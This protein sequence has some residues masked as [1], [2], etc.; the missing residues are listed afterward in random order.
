MEAASA[1]DEPDAPPDGRRRAF[2][3]PMSAH[4]TGSPPFVRVSAGASGA[5]GAAA[6]TPLLPTV[7]KRRASTMSG[8]AAEAAAV[9]AAHGT[10]PASGHH[11][12]P[13]QAQTAGG[14][15]VETLYS[16]PSAKIISFSA[17]ARNFV[18]IGS[19]HSRSRNSRRSISSIEDDIEP[20]TLP[21]NSQFE[22]TIAVNA[23]SIYRAPGSVAF[24]SC[25]SAL[26]PILP[27]SQCWCIDEESSKFILQI[28]RP[29]YWRIEIPVG[30]SGENDERARRF[31]EVLEQ[32]LQFEKT[33]CPFKRAFTVELPERPSTPL[34]KRPWTPVRRAESDVS[35]TPPTS[36]S[37]ASLSK[38]RQQPRR[39]SLSPVPRRKSPSVSPPSQFA[40]PV[41][42]SQPLEFTQREW[43]AML[44]EQTK[45]AEEFDEDGRR[46]VPALVA[47]HERI[48]MEVKASE[49]EVNKMGTPWKNNGGTCTP[50]PADRRG[51]GGGGSR[52]RALSL[53][54]DIS[55]MRQG[56]WS[57]AD[58]KWSEVL[59]SDLSTNDSG[60]PFNS[61]RSWLSPGRTLPPSS[62]P[63]SAGSLAAFPTGPEN[64]LPGLA[65][66]FQ[67]TRKV[68]D[69]TGDSTGAT[70]PLEGEEIQK[71]LL[72]LQEQQAGEQQQQEPQPQP[73]QSRIR[74]RA[75]TSSISVT[76]SSISVT[77]SSISVSRLSSLPPAVNILTP[78]RH[79]RGVT[80]SG[81]ASTR[82]EA[83][84]RI[85][86]SIMY[87]V[88]EILLAPPSY[89]I[90]LMLRVAAR[91]ISGE[92]RGSA[93]GTTDAGESIPV[94]WDYTD[95]DDPLGHK[96]GLRWRRAFNNLSVYSEAD[97][98]DVTEGERNG[99]DGNGKL[100]PSSTPK[101]KST[102]V[103]DETLSDVG[104]DR[105]VWTRRWAVD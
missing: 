43:A 29:Q 1:A 32:V 30:D 11:I 102:T 40:T 73:Q 74:H 101:G 83:M 13:S 99:D 87:R 86:G 52:D 56:G 38:P 65:S 91:I 5:S 59:D 53:A 39:R 4:G 20:G 8:L 51:G 57:S 22:R 69:S 44:Q 31:R 89:L 98:E 97:V 36:S 42:P 103:D 15:V 63:S 76:T 90:T 10:F 26:Q 96:S 58:R 71:G 41:R 2:T 27:K 72:Q 77:T 34:K 33:P 9:A 80:S 18:E 7:S 50:S 93:V 94:Q 47:E 61:V 23:L 66:L 85:P 79:L 84:R 28:R 16:H 67:D 35:Y 70:K 82:L 55:V 105:L 45:A 100:S 25:G 3:R 46:L 64:A 68:I 62:P 49:I 6:A 14:E 92:W 17:G 19:A 48:I 12:D 60:S 95:V 37:L 78:A 104:E 88:M 21:W 81:R 54:S 75:T 24:L